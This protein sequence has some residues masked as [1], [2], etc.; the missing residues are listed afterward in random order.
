MATA[1]AYAYPHTMRRPFRLNRRRVL[2]LSLMVAALLGGLAYLNG[3][4]QQPTYPVL[5]A[6]RDL[7]RGAAVTSSD[8]QP[9]RVALPDAM[10]SAS[11]PAS[12]LSRVVGQRVA[13]PVHAGIPLLEAQVAGPTEVVPGFQR[14]ALPVGPEHAAGGRMNVGD[15]VRIYVTTNRGKADARTVVGLEQ[16]VAS[17]DADIALVSTGPRGLD[18][19]T[20]V[21]LAKRRLPLVVLD[22]QPHHQRWASFEGVVLRSD[23]SPETVLRG[24]DAAMRGEH[25]R[26]PVD[27]PIDATSAAERRLADQADQLVEVR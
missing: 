17:A 4:G 20:L 3:I 22:S 9:Q 14:V 6:A 19:A 1:T 26:Q 25:F 23:A 21:T 27:R 10:A 16:A 8:F 18:H 5:I 2:S 15:T 13:E 24:L 12:A 11:V 7:P